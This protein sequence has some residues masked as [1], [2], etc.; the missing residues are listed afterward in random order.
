MAVMISALKNSDLMFIMVM[1]MMLIKRWR[2]EQIEVVRILLIFI[3]LMLI[4]GMVSKM[5]IVIF[6]TM[7]VK[8]FLMIN[9]TMIDVRINSAAVIIMIHNLLSKL[10]IIMM[11]WGWI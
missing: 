11:N 6:V 3:L 1:M 5:V 10:K 7:N 9:F 4:S 8:V 2:V